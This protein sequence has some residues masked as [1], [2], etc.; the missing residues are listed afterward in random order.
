MTATIDFAPPA[1]P[2]PAAKLAD[3]CAPIL[4]RC[5][6]LVED[7]GL[8]HV[9]QWKAAHPGAFVMG[10]MPIYAPRPLVEAQGGLAVAIFGGG[11]EVDIIRGDSYFQSY[12]CHIPRST[13]E[14]GLGGQFDVLD[15]MMFPSICDVIRN[16]GGMWKLLFPNKYSAYVDLP[17]NFAQGIGGKFYAHELGRIAEEMHKFGA[18]KLEPERLRQALRDENSRRAAI[19]KLDELRR[20]EPHR[21]LASEA[22]LLVRAGAG[23]RATDHTALIEEFLAVA[24][25]REARPR[26][27]VRVVLVGAFCEQAPVDLIRA[28][29]KAGCDI[30]DDDFQLGMR[31]IEGDLDAEAED[32]LLA[33]AMGFIKKGQAVASRYIADEV[34]GKSLIDKVQA[35]K[36]DG[37]IFAAASFCD[38]ALLDQPMLEVAMDAAKIPHTSFKYAENT[39]Q[40]QV[41]RE[42]AGAFSDAV[43]LWGQVE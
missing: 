23:L 29:E 19:G 4:Q 7:H 14:L 43:K 13:I 12:I 35:A 39:G 22:Y 17:Q 8:E 34:K 9:K 31:M 24:K 37:V 36:A 6:V 3:P 10:H 2:A 1:V 16:L 40:F 11:E 26:D 25:K 41:I 20:Q 32:P 33:L 30:V 27:N 15:G 21:C 18:Q 5:R 42:Q 38:P 28:L